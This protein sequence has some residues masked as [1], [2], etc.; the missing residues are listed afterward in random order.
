MG[1]S[2]ILLF[3]RILD[4]LHIL[5][6]RTHVVD[7]VA[8]AFDAKIRLVIDLILI[9]QDGGVAD[10]LQKGVIGVVRTDDDAVII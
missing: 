1:H 9:D 10:I 7:L 3:D 4:R 6:D 5:D 8:S 2:Q